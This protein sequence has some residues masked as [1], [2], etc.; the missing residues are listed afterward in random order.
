M[1]TTKKPVATKKVQPAK[2]AAPARKTLA[3][4]PPADERATRLAKYEALTDAKKAALLRKLRDT[5]RGGWRDVRM[6]LGMGATKVRNE[7]AK[8]V[9]PWQE[10]VV[11]EGVGRPR[12]GASAKPAKVAT[13][14]ATATRKAPAK[15]T[16]KKVVSQ[17][18]QAATHKPTAAKVTTQAPEAPQAASA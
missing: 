14:K 9:R 4:Q 16:A 11:F 10:S 7:Y 12:G 6:A 8:H 18:K 13:K 2:K 15:T 5:D 1:T 3:V 17:T